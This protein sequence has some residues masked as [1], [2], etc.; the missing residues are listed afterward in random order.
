M[1]AS[2]E[3]LLKVIAPYQEDVVVTVEYIFT[4]DLAG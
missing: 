4:W 1:K 3:V 2:P